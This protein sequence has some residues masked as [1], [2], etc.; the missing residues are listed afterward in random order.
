MSQEAKA[1]EALAEEVA[2]EEEAAEAASEEVD[3]TTAMATPTMK[4][5]PTTRTWRSSITRP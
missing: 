5:T 2:T 3:L 4:K 1:A